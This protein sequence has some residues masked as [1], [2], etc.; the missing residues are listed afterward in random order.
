MFAVQIALI[1]TVS[2]TFSTSFL[3]FTCFYYQPV[4]TTEIVHRHMSAH[5]NPH[6]VFSVLS[7]IALHL[8]IKIL[9]ILINLIHFHD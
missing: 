8:T 5:I 2:F 7:I 3:S 1:R 4:F 9:I 6:F